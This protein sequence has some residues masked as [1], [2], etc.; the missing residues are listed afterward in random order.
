METKTTKKELIAGEAKSST[1]IV[2]QNH[3]VGKSNYTTEQ[4]QLIKRT[5]AKDATDDELKL[6]MVIANKHG[7]DP[8]TKQIH[9]VKRGG[10]GTIQT[11]IDGYRAIAER[12]GQLA[13]IEDPVFDSEDQSH[14]KKATVT[15]YKL[16]G[17]Q[18]IP[19]TASARWEEY[20]SDVGPMWKKMPYLMLGK[21]AEALALRKAFPNDL[22]GIYT[23]EEMQQA[24]TQPIAPLKATQKQIDYITSLSEEKGVD[25]F[26]EGFADVQKMTMQEAKECIDHLLKWKPRPVEELPTITVEQRAEIEA[27]G[28]TI[29]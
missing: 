1:E 13:G 25:L 18:R 17:G 14:P 6:F 21:C 7:L 10:I 16:M 8:F 19:F 27:I 9:F 20:K 15:V 29:K 24:D 11:G 12:S 28:E 5:V 23:S 2:A 26:D 22:S 3:Q 4:I